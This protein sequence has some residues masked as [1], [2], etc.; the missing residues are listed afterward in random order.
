MRSQVEEDVIISADLQLIVKESISE[1]LFVG[2][3]NPEKDDILSI[4]Y[5]SKA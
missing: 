3:L 1:V 5:N 4:W 2:K